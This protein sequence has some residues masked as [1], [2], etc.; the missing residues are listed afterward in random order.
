MPV[1]LQMKNPYVIEL[2]ADRTKWHNEYN[3]GNYDGIIDLKNQTWYVEDS[4]QV[5]SATD[6]IGTFN[7]SDANIKHSHSRYYNKKDVA[8][9]E[10]YSNPT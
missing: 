6:N 8:A 10:N 3:K 7:K 4:T 9:I 5:K 2:D 1:Y